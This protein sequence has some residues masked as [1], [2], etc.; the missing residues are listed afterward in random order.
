MDKISLAIAHQPEQAE[1]SIKDVEFLLSD[2]GNKL[3]L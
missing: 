1:T 2:K 3:N